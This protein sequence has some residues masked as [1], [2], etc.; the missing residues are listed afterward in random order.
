MPLISLNIVAVVLAHKV[1]GEHRV[2]YLSTA[3]GTSALELW[4]GQRTGR[5]FLYS[6]D[7][8][9]DEKLTARHNS[10]N[11]I[12]PT[13]PPERLTLIARVWSHLTCDPHE[14][15]EITRSSFRLRRVPIDEV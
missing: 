12:A 7:A 9:Y 8:Y 10:G 14:Y 5:Y 2:E 11:M 3:A 15:V 1:T 4:R 13:P 6:Q